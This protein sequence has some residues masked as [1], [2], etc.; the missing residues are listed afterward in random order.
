MFERLSPTQRE[1][2]DCPGRRIVVK[3]CPGSGKTFSVTARLARLLCNNQ[4]NKHQGI[5][6]ISFTHTACDEIKN[7]I[8]KFGVSNVTYPHFIGTIDSFIN[9]YIFFPYGH[10][11]MGCNKR[12]EVIGTEYN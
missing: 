3:A 2:V 4:L 8:Q 11:F 1:I 9:N 6:A 12:P 7:G 5:A 10:L